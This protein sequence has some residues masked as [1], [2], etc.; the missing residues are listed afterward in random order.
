MNLTVNSTLE[1]RKGYIL[2]YFP[3]LTKYLYSLL[4][5]GYQGAMQ[6]KDTW[7]QDPEANL[8]TQLR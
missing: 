5:L 3:N 2:K 6:A 7:K 8:S 4:Y 1:N